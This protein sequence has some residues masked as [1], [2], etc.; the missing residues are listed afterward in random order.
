[1]AESWLWRLGWTLALGFCVQGAA[2][3]D[4]L[5]LGVRVDSAPFAYKTPDNGYAGFVFELCTFA[6][7]AA[8]LAYAPQD[9]NVSGRLD[10]LVGNASGPREY[11]ILCDPTSITINRARDYVLSAPIFVSGGSF[12]RSGKADQIM[13]NEARE[14]L[15]TRPAVAP[16]GTRF[17]TT[18]KDAMVTTPQANVPDCAGLP[19]GAIVGARLGYVENTTGRNVIDRAWSSGAP[20]FSLSHFQTICATP[21]D[22]HADAVEALCRG[23]ISY[24]FG[25]RD[26]IDYYRREIHQTA[27]NCDA[28]TDDRSFTVEPYAI[29][30]SPELDPEIARRVTAGVLRALG[31]GVRSESNPDQIVA[32]PNYLFAKYFP[33]RRMSDALRQLYTIL[34]VPE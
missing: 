12:L 30:I 1:M 6:L 11:D 2:A 5:R 13:L 32:L 26:I 8:G 28:T 4:P 9:A 23:E 22:S 7:E 17:E 10:R 29:V 33:G 3:Q 27:T 21:V 18:S 16:D 34:R 15:E 31:S 19:E 24:H 25:D 20:P 14:T